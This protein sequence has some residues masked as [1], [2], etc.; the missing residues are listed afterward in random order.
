MDLGSGGPV[1]L[2]EMKDA[3]GKPRRLVAA[4]AKDRNIYL[5]DRNAM[6]KFNPQGNQ[7]IYQELRQALKGAVYR[8]NPRILT[9][10]FTARR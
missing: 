10:G 2:P 5:L 1:V 9:D 4:A 7:N 8:A 6:G 3:S